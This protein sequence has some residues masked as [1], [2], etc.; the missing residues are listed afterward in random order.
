MPLQPVTANIEE[1]QFPP[2][3]YKYRG[4]AET[5][6]KS[7]ITDLKLYFAQPYSFTDEFDCNIPI[8]WDL[9]TKDEILRR[10]Y[11]HS[12]RLNP[13]FNR[14]QHR[15][16]ARDWE[17]KAPFKDS[18]YREEVEKEFREKYNLRTGVLCMT[19]NPKSMY[20]WDKYAINHT[21]ICVGYNPR[22]LFE[23]DTRFGQCGTVDYYDSLPIIHPN[24]NSQD[25]TILQIYSKL[26]EWHQE[27]EFRIV[28]TYP[29]NAQHDDI[30]RTAVIAERGFTE[31]II[32][33][34][35]SEI[36]KVEVIEARNRN[37]PNIA[38]KQARITNENTIE[39]ENI[40]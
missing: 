7:I 20:L 15:K 22:I 1:Y 37:L 25:K 33:A 36:H 18:K 39:I 8:R 4:W 14:N 19:E 6:H 9:L 31:I 2:I 29:E 3:I 13:N 38:L 30:V 21:G 12:L 26:K 23:D 34:N 28:K 40:T 10:Y 5:R 11:Q 24:A 27:E 17:K 16:F 32:G 35:I